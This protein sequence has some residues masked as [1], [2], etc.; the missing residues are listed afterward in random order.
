MLIG[1]DV[2]HSTL[3]K[4]VNSVIGIVSTTNDDFNKYYSTT[5][6]VP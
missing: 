1:A 4:G 2:H 5:Y 6:K 3:T